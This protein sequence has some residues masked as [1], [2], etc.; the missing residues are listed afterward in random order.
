MGVAKQAGAAEEN[1]VEHGEGLLLEGGKGRSVVDARQRG[2]GVNEVRVAA[3]KQRGEIVR[4]GTGALFF[5]SAGAEIGEELD[6]RSAEGMAVQIDLLM[7]LSLTEVFQYAVLIGTAVAGI[8]VFLAVN[9]AEVDGAAE[10]GR[11][12]VCT[13]GPRASHTGP[14]PESSTQFPA[15][16]DAS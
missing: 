6:D 12:R 13:S 3:G 11:P 9:F 2:N 14:A 10:Q 8:P 16:A 1:R 7:G 4:I 15:A 5:G